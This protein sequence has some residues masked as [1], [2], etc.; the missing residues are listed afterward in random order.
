MKWE[1]ESIIYEPALSREAESYSHALVVPPSSL[2]SFYVLLW[3]LSRR[4]ARDCAAAF[5]IWDEFNAETDSACDDDNQTN[6][7][8]NEREG[9]AISY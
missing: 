4:V 2:F 1:Q 8:L 3:R 7:Q 5:Q 6:L 9:G